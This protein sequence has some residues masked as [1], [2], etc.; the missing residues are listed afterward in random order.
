MQVFRL[1][2]TALKKLLKSIPGSKGKPSQYEWKDMRNGVFSAISINKDV[3][4][5]SDS[6]PLNKEFLRAQGTQKNNA[7]SPAAIEMLPLPG[8]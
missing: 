7:C 6:S 4:A 2:D 8:A 1:S 3:T 5:I